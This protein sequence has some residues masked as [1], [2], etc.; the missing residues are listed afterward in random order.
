MR[1][2]LI[3]FCLPFTRPLPRI[4]AGDTSFFDF[5]LNVESNQSVEKGY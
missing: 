5:G 2:G 4:T 1:T 3:A